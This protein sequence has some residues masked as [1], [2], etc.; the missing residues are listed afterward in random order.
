MVTT[1][2]IAD[3]NPAF[4]DIIRSVLEFVGYEVESVFNGHEALETLKKRCF[5]A[6]FLDLNMP[7]L[8]GNG[9]LEVVRSL[10][11]CQDMF[12]V[13]VTANPHMLIDEMDN[14]DFVMMKPIQVEELAKFA[15]RIMQ[16][17]RIS[18]PSNGPDPLERRSI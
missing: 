18:A 8:S 2:L 13:V 17:P 4:Q 16:S 12:I 5:H 3:D 15:E 10:P 1:A 6:L 9:V 11:G 7:I 14:A